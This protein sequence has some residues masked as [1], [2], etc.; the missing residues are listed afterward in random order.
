MANFFDALFAVYNAE[1]YDEYDGINIKRK[2]RFTNSPITPHQ[3]EAIEEYGKFLCGIPE[4]HHISFAYF[5][6]EQIYFYNLSQNEN[7]QFSTELIINSNKID[8]LIK[9]A[10]K[11]HETIDLIENAEL[12]NMVKTHIDKLETF[13]S[14]EG[15]KIPEKLS[16]YIEAHYQKYSKQRIN[17]WLINQCKEY[18][19]KGNVK[20]I[21]QLVD[22]L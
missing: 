1:N 9:I 10:N 6:L 15:L 19:L 2:G 16:T 22:A 18:N 3:I 5:F 11:Y 7:Y 17:K 21:K 12:K 8:K 13:K 20:K 14:L 4:E